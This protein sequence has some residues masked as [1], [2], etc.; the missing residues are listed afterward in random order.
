MMDLLKR[1]INNIIKK[2]YRFFVPEN[3]S[4]S[5]LQGKIAGDNLRNKLLTPKISPTWWLG[6][7]LRKLIDPKHKMNIGKD[8]NKDG[9]TN[10]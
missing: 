1:I 5:M 10:K 9:S 2:I 8:N 6:K 3:W 7:G 4:D